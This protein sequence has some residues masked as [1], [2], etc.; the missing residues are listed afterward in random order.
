MVRFNCEYLIP[1]HLDA[2]NIASCPA[3]F[4][5]SEKLELYV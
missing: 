1:A 3:Q 5:S 4:D 2:F